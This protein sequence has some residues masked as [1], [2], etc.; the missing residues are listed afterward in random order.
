MNPPYDVRLKNEDIIEFYKEIGNKLKRDCKGIETWI[1]SA[2]LEALKHFGLKPDMKIKLM[3]G[4]LPA[5][6][7][8]YILY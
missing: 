7:R 8:K 3:N 5:E 1:F 6:L 4:K 2:N